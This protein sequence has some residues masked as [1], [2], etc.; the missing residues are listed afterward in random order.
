MFQRRWDEYFKQK[1]N[2]NVYDCILIFMNELLGLKYTNLTS[3]KRLHTDIFPSS[4]K[5]VD[6]MGKK[7]YDTLHKKSYTC[8][9]PVTILV[10]KLLSRIQYSLTQTKTK[11]S[12]DK[13]QIL[14]SIKGFRYV[15][16]KN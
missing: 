16:E 13:E 1:K 9:I 11:T 5:F 6:L 14:Y 10:D 2:K 12:D 7:E 8:N 4:K 15:K 3:F